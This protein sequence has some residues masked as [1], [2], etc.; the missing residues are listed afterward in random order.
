VVDES[1][2]DGQAGRCPGISYSDMLA[3]DTREVPDFLVKEN[4]PSAGVTT[5]STERYTSPEFARLEDEK[6]WR[7]VW[8]YAAR[9][10]DLLEPGENIVY[11]NAGRSYVLVRQE[12]GSVRAFHNVCLHRGRKLRTKSG[13][14]ADLKCPFHGFTWNNDGSLKEVPCAWD[15]EHLKDKD[16]SLPELRVESWQGF[17]MVTENQD[18]EPFSEWIGE[19]NTH[20]E[21]WNLGECYTAAWVGRVIPAN[22][23]VTSEA[24]MEAWHSVVT[25]PQ[26]LP[27]TGDANTRYDLYGDFANRAITPSSVLSPHIADDHDQQYVLDGLK[28]FAAQGK[29]TEEGNAA[30]LRKSGGRFSNQDDAQPSI[31]N[32]DPV[33]ARK[34]IAEL[35]RQNFGEA[36][37]R[38][39]SEISDSEM[40]DN[41]TYNI[42]PNFAPWGGFIPN[43]VYRW[44]P[45]RDTDHCLMEIRVLM[46]AKE[47]EDVPAS[48]PM[49][50]IDED[51]PFASASHL[52]S[53]GLASVFDQDM[54]NLPYVQEGLKA[55]AN[56]TIELGNYQESRIAHFH[57]T[58]DKYINDE[59]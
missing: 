30:D 14:A 56:K 58:L 47:G 49:F 39:L 2:Y 51:K 55:S 34:I 40:T 36:Y 9:E 45:V 10:E 44:T 33:A 43:I 31:N 21:R 12:D 18:I 24:F 15:F 52:I 17:I 42:F 3:L 46:R 23:K 6:M 53:P 26:I 4:A 8:Q 41:F 27:F 20:F 50:L 29:K 38:D 13:Y 5:L 11:E 25:H 19:V 1:D 57:R 28:K 54:A 35:N 37:G 22:W 59:I 16:M 7:K 48:P 32:D